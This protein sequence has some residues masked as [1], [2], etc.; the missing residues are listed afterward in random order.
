MRSQPIKQLIALTL[1]F[2]SFASLAETKEIYLTR[3][4]EK[5]HDGTRDPSLTNQGQLRAET[6][7]QFLKSKNIAAIYST[8]YKRTMETAGAT[9]KMLGLEIKHY[10]PSQLKAFADE[11][12]KVKGNALVVGHSN[13]TPD[14]VILLGGD[15]K[16]SIDEK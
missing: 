7:A 5:Q 14:L 2:L 16:G 6:I 13:T 15:D 10:D 4:A 8:N 3:H 1:I 12:K 11:L 9:A